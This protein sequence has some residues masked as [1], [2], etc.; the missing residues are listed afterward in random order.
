MENLITRHVLVSLVL[1]LFLGKLRAALLVA[2]NLPLALL[3]AFFA[4]C[5]PAPRPT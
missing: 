1:W 5:G 4:W 2:L 3:F